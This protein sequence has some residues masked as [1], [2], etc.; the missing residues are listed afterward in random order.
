MV[1]GFCRPLARY[2]KLP[3]P[4]LLGVVGVALG[5]FPAVLSQLGWGSKTDVFGDI[6]LE[7]PVGSATFIYIF[8]PLL[9]FEAGIATDVRRMLQDAAPI[10]LLAV[11]ATLLTTAIIG[12]VLWPLH[13]FHWLLAC[14]SARSWPP[15]TRLRSS[16]SFATSAHRH[17]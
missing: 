16:P 5:G 3:P 7:M 15:P 12:L 8:L 4:V 13:M 6:F 10:L 11:V 2:L 17:A 14:Y 1:I 9:V